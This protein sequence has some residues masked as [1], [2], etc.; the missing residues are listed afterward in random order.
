MKI[1][2]VQWRP[3]NCSKV[4]YNHLHVQLTSVWEIA[5][6]VKTAS[7]KIA[8]GDKAVIALSFPHLQ[9]LVRYELTVAA[10]SLST[11]TQ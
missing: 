3:N 4:S 8:A 5:F 9:L 11:A 6:I 1:L 10:S 2:I 7:I